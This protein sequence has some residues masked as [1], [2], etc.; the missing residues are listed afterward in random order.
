[1]KVLDLFSGI[2]GFSHGLDKVGFKTVAFCEMDEYCKLVCYK[3]IGKELR[4]IMTLK[5]L[6]GKK[7]SKS[8]EQLIL[9]SV[10]FPVSRS[11]SQGQEKEQM[12]TDISGRKC[13]ESS[14]SLSR[15]GLLEKMC[16]VL[17]VSKTAW[18]SR[19]CALTWKEK[20]TK[21][22]RSIFQVAG[23]GAPH[24]RERMRIVANSRR[25]LRQ[26]SELEGEN[27]DE[28]KQENADQYQRSSSTSTDNVA[29]T[30]TRLSNGSV[31]EVQSGRQTFDTSSQ[32]TDVAYTY[33][34]RQQEQCGTESVQKEGNESQRSSSQARHTGW[35]SE[36][37][38]G[39]VAHGL[40]GRVHRLK[41]LGNSI[42]PKIA[43][44]I[45]RAIAI[46]EKKV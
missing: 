35:E 3:N 26:G 9:S 41:A 28:S 29:D 46:A 8:T 15:G 33:S 20:V 11:V 24:K 27:A 7:L 21:S 23:V 22:G 6:K 36:P 40:S 4:Y 16:E 12:T 25:T 17:L 10:A 30:H 18:S 5:N 34:Q 42:V 38:V 19:M 1:M 37:D 45:G 32:R 44:E 13:F 14:K 2:G 31:E 39:R 43:E